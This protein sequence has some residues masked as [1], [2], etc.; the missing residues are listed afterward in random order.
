MH[1]GTVL[2]AVPFELRQ[3]Q[4]RAIF[5]ASAVI[6]RLKYAR[7]MAMAKNKIGL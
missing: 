5:K 6:A 7:S 2:K 4:H 1:E 3:N